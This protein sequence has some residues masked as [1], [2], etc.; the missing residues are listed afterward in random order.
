MSTRIVAQEI[1]ELAELAGVAVA[2]VQHFVAGISGVGSI[3]FDVPQDHC[4]V[5]V[6][7]ED[8]NVDEALTRTTTRGTA[9]VITTE[10]QPADWTIGADLFYVFPAGPVS[11]ALAATPEAGKTYFSRAVGYFLP[12]SAYAMLSRMGTKILS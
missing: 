9:G 3:T 11:I 8:F 12:N 2:D 4:A 5:V 7:I 10:V 1:R 6:S